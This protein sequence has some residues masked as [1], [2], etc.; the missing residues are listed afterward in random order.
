MLD[1]YV[2]T[3]YSVGFSPGVDPVRTSEVVCVHLVGST[4][5]MNQLVG[6]RSI[7]ATGD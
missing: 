2:L 4:T 1:L 6:T 7:H 5:S 3:P